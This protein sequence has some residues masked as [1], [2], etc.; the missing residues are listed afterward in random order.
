MEV[1]QDEFARLCIPWRV[2]LR[3]T[4]RRATGFGGSVWDAADGS[5]AASDLADERWID[6]GD[7]PWGPLRQAHSYATTQFAAAFSQAD[8]MATLLEGSEPA[9]HSLEPLA[10]SAVET[11][12]RAG[13]LLDPSVDADTRALRGMAELIHV[14]REAMRLETDD[15]F[16]R[17]D[18]SWANV[19]AAADRLGIELRY[20]RKDPLPVGVEGVQ[21]PGSRA[22][23]ERTLGKALGGQS[24]AVLSGVT[25]GDAMLLGF[26][27]APSEPGSSRVRAQ[28]SLMDVATITI[29]V[30]TALTTSFRAMVELYGW[31][32]QG[33]DSWTR[34]VLAKA[35]PADLVRAA[36][37]DVN[38]RLQDG[39]LPTD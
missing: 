23:V 25:H 26:S 34:S 29:P 6:P 13:W 33:W 24:Y 14:A 37:E 5:V 32:V 19:R 28:L 15:G 8:G 9:L 7:A 21:R 38:R 1:T 2:A 20:Q 35:R 16:F 17:M 27:W 12:S 39:T 10:R 22:I 4:G 31:D 18:Q 3:S 11:S 36:E 30:L